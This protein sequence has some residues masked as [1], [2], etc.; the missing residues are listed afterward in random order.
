MDRDMEEDTPYTGPSY[1]MPWRDNKQ[2]NPKK[3]NMGIQDTIYR[4]TN[5]LGCRRQEMTD[6]TEGCS[7]QHHI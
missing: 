3:K 4:I 2:I 5:Q 1:L 7:T 6:S